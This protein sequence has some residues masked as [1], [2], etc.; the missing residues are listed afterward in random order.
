MK[1]NIKEI[2]IC[3][4]P[5]YLLNVSFSSNHCLHELSRSTKVSLLFVCSLKV[6]YSCSVGI[7]EVIKVNIFTIQDIHTKQTYNMAQNLPTLLWAPFRHN[8]MPFM[9]CINLNFEGHLICSS[10]DIHMPITGLRLLPVDKLQDFSIITENNTLN[11]WKM[12]WEM[13][14]F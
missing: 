6:Q 14:F 4:V 13:I 12:S 2:L 9:L 1:L 3:E 11:S 5:Q 10:M 7:S 8:S